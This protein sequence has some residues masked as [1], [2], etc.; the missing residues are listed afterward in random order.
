M[1]TE[2]RK[3]TNFI[4]LL[5]TEELSTMLSGTQEYSFEITNTHDIESGLGAPVFSSTIR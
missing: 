5:E 4:Y 3:S 1:K 2:N